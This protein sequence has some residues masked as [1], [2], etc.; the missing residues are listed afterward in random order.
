M[1]T[2]YRYDLTPALM[3]QECIIHIPYLSG[4]VTL[5]DQLCKVDLIRDIPSVWFM[6]DTDLPLETY[7]ITAYGTGWDMGT[8][9]PQDYLGSIILEDYGEIYHF[10]AKRI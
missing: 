7:S 1:T 6:V 10:C 8:T 3:G 4:T 9:I 5:K 2:I